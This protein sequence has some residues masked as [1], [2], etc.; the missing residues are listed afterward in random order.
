MMS[1]NSNLITR[2]A[3][4]IPNRRRLRSPAAVS[5]TIP[6]F[7]APVPQFSDSPG[8]LPAPALQSGFWDKLA[9]D[10]GLS[11][12]TAQFIVFGGAGL[13]FLWLFFGKRR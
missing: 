1:D 6:S 13:F 7:P 2:R 9:S 11:R 8:T 12:S 5:P 10:F 3:R 4:A